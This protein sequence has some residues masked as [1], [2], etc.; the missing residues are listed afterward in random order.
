VT[1]QCLPWEPPLGGNKCEECNSD[2]FRPCSQYRCKSLGQACE[3]VNAGTEEEACTWVNP[4]DVNSPTIQPNE[5]ALRPIGLLDYVPDTTI[6]PPNRGVKI[7]DSRN[8]NG[9]LEPF[10]PLEFGVKVNEPAQCKIGFDRAQTFETMEYYFGESN[11]YRY[12]HT[13]KMRLPSPK[14]S[15]LGAGSPLLENDA[16]MDLFVRCQ[17]ANGNVNEDAFIFTFCVDPSPDTTPP[18]IEGT[19]II[20]N[21]AVQFGV[22]KVPIEVYT[23]EP[24]TCKWSRQSKGYDD[25]EN[26]MTCNLGAD[27]VNADLQYTC[28]GD[29]TGIKNN[30]ENKFYF[31]CQDTEGNTNVQSYPLTLRGSQEL[32]I[33][34]IDPEEGETVT[35]ATSS[36][37]VT[38]SVRT[39]DGS[40]EGLALCYFSNTGVEGSYI[41]M[42]ETNSFEHYQELDLT[43]GNYNYYF[44]CV[45]AG[46]NSAEATVGFSVFVDTVEP[47]VVRVYKDLDALKIVTDEDAQCVYS[48]TDCN[49][50]FDEG[51]SL[52]YSNPSIKKNHFAEWNTKN[53][54]NIKCKD[55][56]GNEPSPNSCSIIVSA[57][58]LV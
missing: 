51:Q 25:M 2:R 11:L 37:P 27:R 12:N 53:T 29:L 38:L 24:A 9:C 40:D 16:N 45:D 13:Q 34:E 21:G 19:S 54:Y 5:E 32:N 30:A 8:T 1:F 17:D 10:T 39:D 18:I 26:A 4:G 3:I 31:R 44:R 7:T 42:F 33:V 14:E 55:E 46:G 6:R 35:G 56:R 20:N 22:D 28:S 23:N 50:V 52:L 36:V 48:L 41:P 15:L 58:D 43:N 57:V 47:K 49:Y